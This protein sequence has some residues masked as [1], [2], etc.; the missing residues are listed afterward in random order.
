MQKWSKKWRCGNGGYLPHH[1]CFVLKRT[2]GGGSTSSCKTKYLPTIPPTEDRGLWLRDWNGVR[3]GW[4]R[5]Q[6]SF[7]SRY[8]FL[9]FSR[10]KPF[11]VIAR[12]CW[13]HTQPKTRKLQQVCWQL[14]TICYNKPISGCVPL[15]C[16][17]LDHAFKIKFWS[18]RRHIGTQGPVFFAGVRVS[19]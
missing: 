16:I 15:I 19:F 10:L 12:L 13:A 17:I 4:E 14:V 9:H 18:H 7:I 5:C 1:A 8:Y 3:G 2:G 6:K 11:T